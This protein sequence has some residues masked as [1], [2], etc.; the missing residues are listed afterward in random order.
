VAPALE[1]VLLIASSLFLIIPGL[2]TDGIG[3]FLLA[4][5]LLIHRSKPGS[6]ESKESH[7]SEHE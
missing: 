3:L 4:A 7:S 1:R 6:R 2:L 5:G